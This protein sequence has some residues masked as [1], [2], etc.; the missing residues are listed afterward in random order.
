VSLSDRLQADLK[1]AMRA[2]DALAR[3]TLRMCLAAFKN[4]SIELQRDLDEGEEL[5]VLTKAVKT[6]QDSAEQYDQAGRD[7]LAAKERAEIE[8]IQRY[9]PQQLDEAGVRAAVEAAIASTGASGKQGLGLVMKAVMAEHRGT[10]D[11]KLVSR[12]AGELLG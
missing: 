9:L 8:I 2:R 7:D 5:Q 6:R 11:G 3:E 10:V 4:A 12:I 1:E